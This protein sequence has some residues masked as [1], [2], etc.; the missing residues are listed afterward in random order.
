VPLQTKTTPFPLKFYQLGRASLPVFDLSGIYN[1]SVENHF[2]WKMSQVSKRYLIYRYVYG[3]A[4]PDST[5]VNYFSY[6]TG[7]NI[8]RNKNI[9]SSNCSRDF[10]HLIYTLSLWNMSTPS[11][12]PISPFSITFVKK[13]NTYYCSVV[14]LFT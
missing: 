2:Y 8:S 9:N 14:V 12:H 4:Y 1:F 7:T 10:L 5:K 11:L 3:H 13:G 6:F